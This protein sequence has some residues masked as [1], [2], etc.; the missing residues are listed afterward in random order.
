MFRLG[1]SVARMFW[2]LFILA[3]SYLARGALR[4]H[5]ARM[6]RLACMV[7]AV[8][9]AAAPGSALAWGA[10][11]HRL[12]GWA[13]VRALPPEVPVFL[14]TRQAA[15]DV[16]ELSR[17]P[18]RSKA[19][20]RVHDADRDPGH[21]V[22]VFDDGT[23]MGG[24]RLSALPPTR[25]EYDAALRAAGVDSWK[26][27]YLPYSIID[28]RQQLAHDFAYWRVLKAAEAN[29]RWS[30]HRAW[31]AADRRRR[32]AQIFQDI[33]Q[34]SH[35]VGD[36]SQPLHVTIHFNGWGELPN[37]AGYTTAKIHAPFEGELVRAF[38]RP[39]DVVAR[40]SPLR[41]CRCAIEQRTADY[42]AETNRRVLPLYE[43]E[44]AGALAKG[45]RRGVA[46]A[47]EQLAR[48]ASELRDVI[49]EAWIASASHPV[50]WPAVAPADVAAGKA[51]PYP[52]L[53]GTD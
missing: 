50:G 9:L 24:P 8:I 18:D 52:S 53:Y 6:N 34:L 42:L 38:V 33:G 3:W 27:G 37:P 19:A 31:F 46:F 13:A 26:A 29:P 28:R 32:E 48:G 20:G 30:G 14:R 47:T 21:F 41:L 11:G 23:V 15:D 1:R 45:D 10:T 40:M 22:D 36:G 4:S 25:A 16:G 2:T 43:L 39:A 35:F 49:V 51:D 44:K 12:I 5:T 7:L 17:E